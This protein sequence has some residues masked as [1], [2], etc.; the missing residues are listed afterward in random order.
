MPQRVSCRKDTRVWTRNAS[1]RK[2][3][4]FLH[5]QLQTQI[6]S[7]QLT[8]MQCSSE[9]VRW[10]CRFRFDSM[11][12]ACAWFRRL[13]VP[14]T[15]AKD[16]LLWL[17]LALKSCLCGSSSSQPAVL[18]HFSS[19]WG[20]RVSFLQRERCTSWHWQRPKNCLI[21]SVHPTTT[22]RVRKPSALCH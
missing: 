16:T 21:N 6:C 12:T 4:C 7:P 15:C 3:A 22:A 14:W 10:L 8:I 9:F 20:L 13:R 1:N 18:F 5:H 2:S 19:L 17:R 11:A